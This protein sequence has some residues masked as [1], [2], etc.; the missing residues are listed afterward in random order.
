M[1]GRRFLKKEFAEVRIKKRQRMH[2][3]LHLLGAGLPVQRPVPLSLPGYPSST[4]PFTG[5]TPLLATGFP[6]ALEN[7][8]FKY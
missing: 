2:R 3:R 7:H 4:P 8:F 5:C 1:E 6:T